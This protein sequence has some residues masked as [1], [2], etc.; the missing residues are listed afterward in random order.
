MREAIHQNVSPKTNDLTMTSGSVAYSTIANN[1]Q[2]SKVG[3]R[4]FG[5]VYFQPEDGDWQRIFLYQINF[6]SAADLYTPVSPQENIATTRVG[7]HISAL[8]YW[9]VLFSISGSWAHD[10]PAGFWL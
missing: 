10:R 4:I 7:A 6:S 5:D 3:I 9:P 8:K 2:G 1:L